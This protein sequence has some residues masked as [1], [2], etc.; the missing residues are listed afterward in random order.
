MLQTARK[1]F[2]GN[3]EQQK[4]FEKYI[5]RTRYRLSSREIIS[6]QEYERRFSE[7]QSQ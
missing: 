1:Q 2:K 6:T 4:S 5:E 7:K 3:L